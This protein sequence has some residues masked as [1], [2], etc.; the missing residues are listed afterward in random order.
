MQSVEGDLQSPI[1]SGVAVSSTTP[2]AVTFPGGKF[3]GCY[4]PVGF[5]AN[6]KTKL[7][8]GADNSLYWPNAAMTVN[9]FRAYF[10]LSSTA[11]V[12]NFVLNLGD[13]DMTGIA[14]LSDDANPD[15]VWYNL[16]GRKLDGKPSKKGVYIHSTSGSLQ[17]KKVVIK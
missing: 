1:F 8:V 16:S 17:G 11:G 7:Y 12:R 2:A 13:E 4:S 5:T 14:T 10:D 6:D 15:G 9:A 3:V